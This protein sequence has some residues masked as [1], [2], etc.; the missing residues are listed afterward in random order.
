MR[1]Q[2]DEDRDQCGGE[3]DEGVPP[4]KDV[5]DPAAEKV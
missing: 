2:A 3:K 4:A 1:Q 5:R